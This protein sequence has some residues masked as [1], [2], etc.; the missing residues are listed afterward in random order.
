MIS[1]K[2]V[3]NV[4][5]RITAID[6]KV[7][8][9]NLEIEELECLVSLVQRWN[10]AAFLV[11]PK[12]IERLWSRHIVDSLSLAPVVRRCGKEEGILLDV[13]AGG[14]FPALPMKVVLP[15]LRVVLVERSFRRVSFLKTVVEALEL[16]DVEIVHGEF[17]HAVRDRQ[18]DIITAR[19]VDKPGKIRKAVKPFVE[20]GT[21]FL[22]QSG[23]PTDVFGA[24][25]HVERVEDEWTQ[26]GLRLG[27]LHVVRRQNTEGVSRGTLTILPP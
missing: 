16:K 6:D 12:D 11:S 5:S 15:K 20:K 24:G 22:C 26:E 23:D 25:F 1:D 18:P 3:L 7:I 17:P 8:V 19:A 21:V 9:G 10:K 2:D 4:L 27:T 14:G 13:G